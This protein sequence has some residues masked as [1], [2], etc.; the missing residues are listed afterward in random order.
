MKKNAGKKKYIYSVFTSVCLL[1]TAFFLVSSIL[2]PVEFGKDPSTDPFFAT[3]LIVFI[4][5]FCSIPISLSYFFLR[6]ISDKGLLLTMFVYVLY[7]GLTINLP[8]QI[9]MDLFGRLK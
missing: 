2:V 3:I 9:M 8:V 5:G 4:Y 1:A 6:K 7:I